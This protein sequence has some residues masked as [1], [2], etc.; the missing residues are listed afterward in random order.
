MREITQT[1]EMKEAGVMEAI[2]D[3]RTGL[4]HFR[5]F[6]HQLRREIKRAERHRR[7]FH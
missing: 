3:E 2:L 4:Y 1:K 5:F 6:E 7:P